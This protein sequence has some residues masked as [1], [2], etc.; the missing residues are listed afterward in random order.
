[1]KALEFRIIGGPILG[2]YCLGM[3]LPFCNPKG[4]IAGVLTSLTFMIW[5]FVGNNVVG[6]KYPKKEFFT[7]GCNSTGVTIAPPTVENIYDS[8][9]FIIHIYLFFSLIKS[10]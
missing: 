6:I 5:L 3:F 9:Y 4:A 8:R 7:Y 10:I 1:M 2:L